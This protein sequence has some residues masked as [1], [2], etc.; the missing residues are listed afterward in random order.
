MKPFL[1]APKPAPRQRRPFDHREWKRRGAER[2]AETRDAVLRERIAEDPSYR[3]LEPGGPLPEINPERLKKL[4][5]EQFAIA[6]GYHKWVMEQPCAACGSF[7]PDLRS[8][9]AHVGRTRGAGAKADRVLSLCRECHTF[10]GEHRD[11][12]NAAFAERHGVTPE[13]M[14]AYRFEFYH[15]EH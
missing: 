4:R 10:E 6:S 7:D 12:F 3:V 14:A 5:E 2:Y 13:E 15:R 9:P 11:E 8:D 1:P